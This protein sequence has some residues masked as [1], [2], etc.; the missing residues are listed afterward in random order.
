VDKTYE[1]SSSSLFT[2]KMAVNEDAQNALQP[3]HVSL[4]EWRDFFGL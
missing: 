3:P 2:L 1:W 4:L